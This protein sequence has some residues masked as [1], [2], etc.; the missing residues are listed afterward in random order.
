MVA[1]Y[2]KVVIRLWSNKLMDSICRLAVGTAQ[3]GL[4][5]GI[6]NMDGQVN[7]AKVGQI[8]SLAQSVG[9]DMLDT[10][11][12]YG[13]SEKVLGQVGANDWKIVSKLPAIPN[14]IQN[15]QRW[16]D[17][18]ITNSL[19]NLNCQS[20]YAILLHQPKQLLGSQGAALYA[21]LCSLKDRSVVQKI[22]ISIYSPSD[23]PSLL[24]GRL[25]DIV[26]L[27]FNIIDRSLI[28]SGW[29]SRLKLQG[30]EL[31]IRSIFL[32]G[33]LLMGKDR[34][35][36]FKKWQPLWDQFD[37]WL[38]SNHLTALEACLRYAL[39]IEGVNR[40]VV[41]FESRD[42]LNEIINATNGEI[43][44]LPDWSIPDKQILLN[45]SNWSQ[46]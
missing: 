5:Y 19:Q 6:S 35:S 9:I 21:A 7:L 46:L 37:S 41:G 10:A 29:H 22:G 33:L 32:Q 25:I 3:F 16:I 1:F 30:I 34:P 26:Q 43:P 17:D 8:L 13:D 15:I 4:S 23:L 12:N 27:P 40:I 11:I 36:K 18:Q 2:G 31:H 24:E 14:G 44:K 20:L 39:S 42:Q 28:E 38:E 45:P